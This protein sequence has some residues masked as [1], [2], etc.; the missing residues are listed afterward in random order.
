M[1]NSFEMHAGL[2]N[3]RYYLFSDDPVTFDHL[4]LSPKGAPPLQQASALTLLHL[5]LPNSMSLIA[6]PAANLVII[7]LF[8]HLLS[9]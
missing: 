4:S 5:L 8:D 6:G 7:P 3:N 1:M 9:H 2:N